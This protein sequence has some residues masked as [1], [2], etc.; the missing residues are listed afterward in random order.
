[1]HRLRDK[2]EMIIV[3][4]IVI[5]AAVLLFFR[6]SHRAFWG[7]EMAV[8][9]Y[10]G[11]TPKIFFIDYF[12]HPDNHA[13][14]YYFLVLITYKI[15]PFGELGVRLVSIFSSLAMLVV[16]YALGKK[17]F[18]DNVHPRIAIGLAVVSP[19]FILIGQMARYHSLAAFFTL[20]AFYFFCK[21]IWLE[22]RRR[23]YVYLTLFS[24]LVGLTDYPHFIYILVLFNAYVFY[25]LLK[26]ICSVHLKSWVISQ[27]VVCIS[28]VPMLLLLYN[29]IVIQG[30]GGFEKRNLLG[31]GLVHYL[32][33]TGMHVYDF[34][35][36]E[37][38]FPW[39]WGVFVPI[40][41]VLLVCL[42]SLIVHWKKITVREKTIIG[43]AV[44]FIV[45][46]VVFMN[47]ADSRYNFTVI[48]KFGFVAFP[49]SL[50][51]LTICV[52]YLPKK[53]KG[54]C[55]IIYL[56]AA[57]YG[58]TNLYQAKNYLNASYFNTFGNFRFVE[59]QHTKGDVLILNANVTLS[60]YEFYRHSYF[61]DMTSMTLDAATSTP[62][63]VNN[64][65]WYFFTNAEGDSVDIP[66]ID[67]IP[68]GFKIMKR[69]D[70][71]PQDVML[72]KYKGMVLHRDGYTYKYTVFLLEKI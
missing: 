72:K 16:M 59:Q 61:A 24:I 23:E 55:L 14:L 3:T 28:F 52:K 68:E 51:S 58:L 20:S 56:A 47:Y 66:T 31:N 45:I 65:Y 49:L 6:I 5:F 27:A 63:T 32:L 8:L 53:I 36:G 46:N 21:I 37:N 54:V 11:K 43:F 7:D 50:L 57:V 15:F 42:G 1:M 30:D 35:I 33:A 13:P 34:F 71:V 19:F 70:D 60:T 69:F 40:S 25:T 10:I 4:S 12:R 29:R 2:K 62:K 64:R 41:V 48:P 67:A 44:A 22:C 38:T 39:D 17:V 9:E 26:K 18:A